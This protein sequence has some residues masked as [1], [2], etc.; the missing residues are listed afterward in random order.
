MR[1]VYLPTFWTVILD[2]VAWATIQTFIAYLA[3]RLPRRM[4]N[5]ESWLLKTRPWEQGGNVYERVFRVRRWKALLPSGGTLFRG[6]FSMRKLESRQPDHIKTWV[7][8]SCRSEICHW[9]AVLPSVLFFLWN[10]FFVGFIMIAYA[11]A[12]NAPCIIA[13]RYNRPRFQEILNKSETM[14]S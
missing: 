4:L 10:P 1:I 3:T 13:Q 2:C 9:I 14:P 8:E 5:P 11:I 7:L 12:F 6:G